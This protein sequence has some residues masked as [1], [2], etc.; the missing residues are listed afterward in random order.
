MTELNL[1]DR[2]YDCILKV[3]QTVADLAASITPRARQRSRQYRTFDRTL[4]V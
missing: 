1:S 4:W 2:A 3:S